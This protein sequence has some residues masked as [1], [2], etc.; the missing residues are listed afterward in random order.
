MQERIGPTLFAFA[1]R[2]KEND[3]VVDTVQAPPERKLRCRYCRS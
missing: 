3:K 1:L 2:Q